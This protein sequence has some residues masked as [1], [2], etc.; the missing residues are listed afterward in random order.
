M[1]WTNA[2]HLRML[3]LDVH[4]LVDRCCLVTSVSIRMI[5]LACTMVSNTHQH[6]WFLLD[7]RIVFVLNEDGSVLRPKT[8]IA[9]PS[10]GLLVILIIAPLMVFTIVTRVAV[11]TSL[12]RQNAVMIVRSL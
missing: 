10:A 9:L 5:V 7:A 11:N 4:V 8:V 1:H 6:Q 2:I 3:V 12:L